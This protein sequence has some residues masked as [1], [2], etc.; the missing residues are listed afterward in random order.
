MTK[1]EFLAVM[2]EILDTE[3]PLTMDTVLGDLEEWD[4]LSYVMFQAQMLER[5]HKK[6]DPKAVKEAHTLAD[7][8]VLLGD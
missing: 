8:Y 3:E 7:L 1:E 6:M 5:L 2:D 4:S